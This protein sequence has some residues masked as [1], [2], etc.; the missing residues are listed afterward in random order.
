MELCFTMVPWTKL[1]YYGKKIWYY[2]KKNYGNIPFT[3]E[4]LF[5]MEKHGSYIHRLTKTKKL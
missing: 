5:T 3:L 2:G 1:W 4:F